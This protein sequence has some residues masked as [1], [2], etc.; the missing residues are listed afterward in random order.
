MHE[1]LHRGCRTAN[2]DSS[3]VV[4]VMNFKASETDGKTRAGV[5]LILS[6]AQNRREFLAT[7]RPHCDH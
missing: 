1:I 3:L 7:L 2:G 6:N 4:L 5:I